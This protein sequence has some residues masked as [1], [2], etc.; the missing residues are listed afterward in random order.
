MII[1][2]LMYNNVPSFTSLF[3]NKR[4]AIN[5]MLHNLPYFMHMT[6]YNIFFSFFI[7]DN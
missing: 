2:L 5:E 4:F 7:S 3:R 1:V 6:T